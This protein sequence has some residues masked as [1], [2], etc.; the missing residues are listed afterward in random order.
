MNPDV[1]KGGAEAA[2]RHGIVIVGVST[3]ALA[4]SAWRAGFEC[5]TVDA[6]GDLDQKS[7][8]H[9]ISFHR[10]LNR[11]YS[12]S[13]AAAAAR[14]FSARAAAYVG[15]LENHPDAVHRLA[16]GRVLLGNPPDVL[17]RARDPFLLSEVVGATGARTPLT[18]RPSEARCADPNRRWLRKPMR[19][20]GGSG[21]RPWRPG[22]PLGHR[23][24]AQEYVEGMPASM[25]FLADGRTAALL[26]LS[27]QLAGN[28]A[29][30]VFGA[31]GF[32]YA[33]SLY[34]LCSPDVEPRVNPTAHPSLEDQAA[35]VATAVTAAFG[36]RGVNG[37]DLVLRDDE[38]FVLELNPRY[39]ASAELIERATGLSIF[40]AHT[41]ACLG[42][43][44]IAGCP[45]LTPGHEQRAAVWGKAVL[46]ARDDVVVGDTSCWLDDDG[47]RDIP[48]PDE[49]IPG[50]G[51]V[52]TVFARGVT[53]AECHARLV[54]K[55]HIV[56]ANLHRS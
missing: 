32:R 36:L 24:I 33:G 41:D 35:G 31:T 21:V 49:R 5:E 53:H 45:R 51:P 40:E 44:P 11:R 9:N 15:N 7:S 27:R 34:P 17:E 10:D 18:L 2:M 14:R 52:C 56:E 22:E 54:A 3:R 37:L 12:A 16:A 29:E 1:L 48:F 28:S 39:P 19:G 8:V 30:D 50:G 25:V 20:G 13:A 38:L 43:I 55:T 4:E 23:E 26:G 47:I 46:Y 42:H 6:F